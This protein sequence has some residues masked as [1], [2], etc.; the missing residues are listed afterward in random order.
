MNSV[1]ATEQDSV[2]KLRARSDVAVVSPPPI[3]LPH[4]DL[5]ATGFPADRLSW[6][7]L[8]LLGLGLVGVVGGRRRSR[9]S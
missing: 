7:A 9:K 2:I 4:H 8:I 3:V 1:S 6:W 5:P